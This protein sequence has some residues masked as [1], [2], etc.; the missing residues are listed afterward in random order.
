MFFF[1]YFVGFLG[2]I[3]VICMTI[4]FVKAKYSAVNFPLFFSLYL[5]CF[6]VTRKAEDVTSVYNFLYNECMK[7]LIM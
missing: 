7:W 6:I 3:R 5:S 2:V 1:I 4:A